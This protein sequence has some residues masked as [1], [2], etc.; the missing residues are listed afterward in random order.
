[1]AFG[2]V[3]T[4]SMK[5]RDAD[6]AMPTETGIGLMPADIAAVIARGPIIFVAAVWLVSS[7][8]RLSLIHI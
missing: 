1:M 8:R 6:S 7:E 4:G 3:D 2:G 5:P